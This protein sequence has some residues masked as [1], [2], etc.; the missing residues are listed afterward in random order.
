MNAK[1]YER[2]FL[3]Q[4][5]F[6]FNTKSNYVVNK[7]SVRAFYNSP[8]VKLGATFNFFKNLVKPIF[9]LRI[10]LTRLSHFPNRTEVQD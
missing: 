2:K 4:L 6:I 8:R 1:T 10:S 7:I 3:C 9:A 5:N